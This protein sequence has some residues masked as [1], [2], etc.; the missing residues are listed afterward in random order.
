VW[1]YKKSEFAIMA[2]VAHGSTYPH[3]NPHIQ[4]ELALAF[5]GPRVKEIPPQKRK[6]A[7]CCYSTYLPWDG[8]K[9]EQFHR[10]SAILHILPHFE[11]ALLFDYSDPD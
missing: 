2:A 6:T 3:S 8:E 7:L 1:D 4:S 11:I 10:F 9:N 5:W